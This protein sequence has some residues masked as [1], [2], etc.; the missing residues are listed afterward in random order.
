MKFVKEEI[1]VINYKLEIKGYKSTKKVKVKDNI[2]L[3]IPSIRFGEYSISALDFETGTFKFHCQIINISS[4]S[5]G[6]DQL[7][8]TG[9]FI[10]ILRNVND[11]SKEKTHDIIVY[12]TLEE[13]ESFYIYE[14]KVYKKEEYKLIK[15]IN[16]IPKIFTIPSDTGSYSQDIKYN[17]YNVAPLVN[18]DL[19]IKK[20]E[21][22]KEIFKKGRELLGIPN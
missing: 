2:Y 13:S 22:I 5:L 19:I 4:V 17:G 20:L 15:N 3:L 16:K 11:I 12:S 18:K 6:I 8:N 9:K 7:N 1:N 21:I 14:D 10:D